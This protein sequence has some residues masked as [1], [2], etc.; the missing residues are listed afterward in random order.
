MSDA[1]IRPYRLVHRAEVRRHH[2]TVPPDKYLKVIAKGLW[3]REPHPTRKAITA[4]PGAKRPKT[5]G[6][7]DLGAGLAYLYPLVERM[8]VREDR[9]LFFEVVASVPLGIEA[10]PERIETLLRRRNYKVTEKIRKDMPLN[11]LA[12]D[13][14]LRAREIRKRFALD[15][16]I[17]VVRP[18][19]FDDYNGGVRQTASPLPPW[20]K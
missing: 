2:L 16:L 18:M 14:F 15:Y 11:I 1:K 9:L 12:G 5:V 3:R 13:L 7:W 8:N 17:G 6:I 10:N 19:I 20:T 4:K